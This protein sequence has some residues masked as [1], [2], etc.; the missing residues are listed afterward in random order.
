MRRIVAPV[1][2]TP[3]SKRIAAH[4]ALGLL[5]APFTLGTSL[6]GTAAVT[7]RIALE[8]KPKR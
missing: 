6:V 8:R 2:T 3:R 4:L 1:P 5:L 7:S